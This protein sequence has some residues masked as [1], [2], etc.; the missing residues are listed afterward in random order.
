[1]ADVKKARAK[2]ELSKERKA[3]MDALKN[4]NSDQQKTVA[5]QALKLVRFK[6]VGSI[7]ADAAIRALKNLEKVADT[8]SY[9]WTD[10]QAQKIIFAIEPVFK[11]ILVALT[12]P[13]AKTAQREKFS[14]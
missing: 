4:A 3:A 6:E 8:T 7:R 10:E 13:G 9:A 2:K 11:R 12:K 5:K 14:L 1:M